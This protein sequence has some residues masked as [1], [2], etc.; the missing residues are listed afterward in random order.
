MNILHI[1]NGFTTSKLYEELISRLDKYGV[2]QTIIAPTFVAYKGPDTLGE[3]ICLH[4]IER[5]QSL[6]KRFCFSAKIRNL[7]SYIEELG[8]SDFDLS[9]AHTLFSDGGVAHNIYLRYGIPYIVAVRNS[10]INFFFK[11][12]VHKRKYAYDILLD[13]KLIICISPIY[14]HRLKKIL[15]KKVFQDI[16]NRIVVLPNG[17]NQEWIDSVPLEV[18]KIHNPIRLV[19]CGSIEKNK[20]IHSII[21]ASQ[22]LNKEGIRNEVYIIGKR[23]GQNDRYLKQIEDRLN[24]TRGKIHER[25]NRKELIDI[26]AQADIFVMPSFTETFGLV[27]AEALSQKLPVIYTKNEGFDGFFTDGKIGKS[28]LANNLKDIVG[29][30]KFIIHNYDIIER[31]IEDIE[32]GIFNWDKISN[33]YLTHYQEILASEFVKK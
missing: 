12:F 33:Q 16:E 30:I 27:Y 2:K 7:T 23:A 29:G 19:Y 28:V 26:Y 9:H 18:K 24:H 11:Y 32:Y 10:D 31:N 13:A 22:E 21:R 5:K 14:V 4:I 1:C 25:M 20:N 8:V 6:L 17:I 15:P 3:N